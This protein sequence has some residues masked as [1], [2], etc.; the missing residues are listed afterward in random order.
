MHLCRG[1]IAKME[2]IHVAAEYLKGER[3]WPTIRGHKVSLKPDIRTKHKRKAKAPTG[4]L[5]IYDDEVPAKEKCESN[6]RHDS[7]KCSASD[8]S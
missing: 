5:K 4:T 7:S 2:N 3:K 8:E 1:A 6:E